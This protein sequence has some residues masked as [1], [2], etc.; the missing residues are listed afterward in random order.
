MSNIRQTFGDKSFT[1]GKGG[2]SNPQI[3]VVTILHGGVNQQ[4]IGLDCIKFKENLTTAPDVEKK[5]SEYLDPATT[6]LTDGLGIGWKVINGEPTIVF[7]ANTNP[8][9]SSVSSL[10]YFA[11]DKVLATTTINITGA[12]LLGGGNFTFTAWIPEVIL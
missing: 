4:L 7:V 11:G 8:V 12:A 6:D 3:P 2:G 9:L 10:P 1:I 5:A